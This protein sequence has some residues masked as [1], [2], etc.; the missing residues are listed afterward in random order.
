MHAESEP[1]LCCQMFLVEM[2]LFALQNN[3]PLKNNL[4]DAKRIHYCR[5]SYAMN[6]VSKYLNHH[7]KQDT[8]L[9]TA[10]W[11]HHYM[12]VSPVKLPVVA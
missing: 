11:K 7:R 10:V 9:K 4:H 8:G 2:N 1:V 3:E 5:D 6:N 12:C